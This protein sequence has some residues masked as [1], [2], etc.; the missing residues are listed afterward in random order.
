MTMK[1]N[2][3]SGLL[4]T[5][6]IIGGTMLFYGIGKIT[7]GVDFIKSLLAS[8]RMPSFLAYGVYLGEILAP[9]LLIVGYKT[10]LAGIL[11][12]VNCLTI[13]LLSQT[14]NI[15]K[16]NAYGGWAIELLSIYLVISISFV[17][18][19]GGKYALSTSGKW[20]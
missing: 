5:R 13:I 1:K 2:Y 9:V 12:A 11:F 10:R 16:L 18:T 19:G 20:D 8:E 15:L 14:E 3:D 7:H 17:L 6:L 4:L